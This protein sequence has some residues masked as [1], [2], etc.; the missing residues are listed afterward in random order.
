[1]ARTTVETKYSVKLSAETSIEQ[2]YHY[3]SKIAS[4]HPA[5]PA[6]A[7]PAWPSLP[8]ETKYSVKLSAETSIEQIYHY[9]TKIAIS[10]C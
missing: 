1:M 10:H 7:S 2:I 6:L 8:V 4:S 3:V 9:V 5:N